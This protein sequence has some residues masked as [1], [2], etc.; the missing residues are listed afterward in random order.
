M[1]QECRETQQSIDSFPFMGRHFPTHTK[2][3][4]NAKLEGNFSSDCVCFST[5]KSKK[6]RKKK[7]K[8]KHNTGKVKS[9]RMKSKI[10]HIS[11]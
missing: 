2:K 11:K 8:H 9:L 1:W 4:K 5:E 10:N 6:K 7:H 3:I